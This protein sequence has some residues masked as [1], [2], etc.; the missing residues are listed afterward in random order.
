MTRS[1]K[2]QLLQYEKEIDNNEIFRLAPDTDEYNTSKNAFYT[3]LW[4][5]SQINYGGT[6]ER[7]TVFENSSCEFIQTVN[8]CLK[9]YSVET[10]AFTNY[11]NRAFS[12]ELGKVRARLA[13]E[14]NNAGLGGVTKVILEDYKV[15]KCYLDDHPQLDSGKLRHLITTEQIKLKINMKKALSALDY[16]DCCCSQS[17]DATMDDENDDST[18]ANSLSSSE[19]VEDKVID[20]LLSMANREYEILKIFNTVFH[21]SEKRARAYIVNR[22]TNTLYSYTHKKTSCVVDDYSSEAI[23]NSSDVPMLFDDDE[24]ETRI[25]SYQDFDFWSQELYV[26]I[27]GRGK[28]LDL[29]EIARLSSKSAQSGSQIWGNYKNRVMIK[30]REVL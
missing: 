9:T 12:L 13:K 19:E 30:I 6:S 10:G 26:Q 2:A 29:N 1:E 23:G 3:L 24:I 28:E 27:L 18:I 17:I 15:I 14:T 25:R 11:F 22:L 7:R 16:Y 8:R 4:L 21:E 5:Y 20:S